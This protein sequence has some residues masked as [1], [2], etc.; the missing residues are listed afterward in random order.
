MSSARRKEC[1]DCGSG[2]IDYDSETGQLICQD[3]GSLFEEVIS[4]EDEEE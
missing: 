2:S 1:P 4:D 3:C